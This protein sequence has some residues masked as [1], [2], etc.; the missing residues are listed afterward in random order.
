MFAEIQLSGFSDEIDENFD[1][2]MAV[3]PKLSMRYIEIRGVDGK[4]IADLTD[5]ELQAVPE[6]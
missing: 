2:Q 4:N 5:E 3:I 6:W 1:R